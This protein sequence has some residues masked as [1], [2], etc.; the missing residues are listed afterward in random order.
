MMSVMS[1]PLV[2]I[3][4]AAFSLAAGELGCQGVQVRCPVA[5]EAIEPRVHVLQGLV[6]YSV[7]TARPVRPNGSEAAIAQHLEVLRH[8]RLGD[9]E[10]SLNDLADGT[11]G[12]FAIGEQL[13]DAASDGVTEDVE[14][15]HRA[16]LIRRRLY[17]SMLI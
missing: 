13:Q 3:A 15:M 6:L 5:A 9:A 2:C 10:L 16:Y 1:F 8:G 14:G 17:K 12:L 4:Q 7:E 11:R